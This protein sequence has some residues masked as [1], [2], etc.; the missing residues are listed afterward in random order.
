MK[1]YFIL[2][3]CLLA[4][5]GFAQTL[6]RGPYLQV[7]TSTS[8]IVRWDTDSATDSKVF[9]GTDMNNLN[10]NESSSSQVVKHKVELSNLAPNT[11]YYYSVG[12]SSQTLAA[13]NAN[14][15]FYTAPVPGSTDPIRVWAIGDFGKGN[16]NQKEVR[17]AYQ[18]YLGNDKRTNV[19]IWLG[20]NAYDDGNEQEYTNKVF[21]ATY[22]YQDL[23]KY[24]PFWPCP[25]NHDYHSVC[26]IPCG[27]N[28]DNHSG[29]YYDI[30][31][32]PEQGEAGGE[33]SGVPLYYSFDYGNAH[34]ISLNSEIGSTTESYDWIGVYSS[35]GWNN[36]PMKTWL[37]NDLDQNDKTWTIAY[38]HQLPFS[39]GSHDSDDFWEIYM[40][41]MRENVVPLLESYGVDIV[42]CGHSHNYE[43]SF[44]MNGFYGNSGDFDKT[45]HT[46]DSSSG[47]IDLCEPYVKNIDQ[48][49]GN[50]GT[51]YV[52]S[53]NGASDV[54][55]AD[56][57]HPIMYS[58]DGGDNVC[59]SVIFEIEGNRLDAFY[60]KS[61]STIGD[62]FTIYKANS[63]DNL[64][65]CDTS[66]TSIS[67]VPTEDNFI[68]VFPH[69]F[70]E[71]ANVYYSLDQSADVQVDL[72]DMTGRRIAR[73][74]DGILPAGP[75]NH[76][77]Y[78]DKLGMT[79]G[80]F[81]LSVTNGDQVSFKKIV[82]VE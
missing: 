11:K 49:N 14:Q 55:D 75:Q 63:S 46:I 38:W 9:Y 81:L 56:L 39:K 27:Q 42:I 48:T 33:A 62:R 72:L 31:S 30:V 22:A 7:N 66:T 8:T 64:D 37:E 53:G 71:V 57:N 23:F 54:N 65:L 77:I 2:A 12:N 73:I 58:S 4:N 80:M 59:G 18:N 15:Y 43:R 70:A 67:N 47:N 35:D 74:H 52:V 25:G 78:P 61:D 44:L 10:M 51:V 41:A 17:D 69:P 1:H 82:K 28:P 36:S 45:V 34:F 79:K 13:A 29:V 16:Q 19:W 60:L 50:L 40:Q 6:M 3:I 20:D 68:K 24:T 32:V 21:D 26:P 76:Y 5:I